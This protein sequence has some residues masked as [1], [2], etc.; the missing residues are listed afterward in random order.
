MKGFLKFIGIMSAFFTAVVGALVVADRF[1]NR[2]RLTGD[3][4]QCD[5]NEDAE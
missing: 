4:L 1:L 2:N 5:T 3:Y